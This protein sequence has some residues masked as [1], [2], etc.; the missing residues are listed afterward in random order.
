MPLIYLVLTKNV[1]YYVAGFIAR[2]VKKSI[3]CKDCGNVLGNN[4][5]IRMI[6]DGIATEDCQYFLDL[7]NRGGLMKPSDIV[8]A[9]C[10]VAWEVY[11]RIMESYDA[12]SYFLACKMQRKVFIKSV[13]IETCSHYT[14]S[15]ILE[16]SCLQ[17][18]PFEN[19]FVNIVTKLFNVM[20]KH[21]ASEVNSAVHKDKKRM[22]KQTN[23]SPQSIKIRK[24][25]SEK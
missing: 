12:K 24:L 4:T 11:V 14:Y 3:K 13:L 19:I 8:F 23:I 9:V 22:N 2:S 25:Q 18:H 6:L 7:V 15:S 16:T 5:E 17:D 1:I 20:C 10:C 21:F